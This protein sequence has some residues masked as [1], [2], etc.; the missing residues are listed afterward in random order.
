M[1]VIGFRT[2]NK[3]PLI[4]GMVL[5]LVY[6]TLPNHNKEEQRNPEKFVESTV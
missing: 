6:M 1:G 4:T 2:G 5:I 3:S